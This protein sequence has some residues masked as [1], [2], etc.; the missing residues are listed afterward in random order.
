MRNP[1][2][3]KRILEKIGAIWVDD[4]DQRFFQLLCN[5]IFPRIGNGDLFF[6]EDTDLEAILNEILNLRRKT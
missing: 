5:N 4:P 3:I 6:V 1:E 2:R